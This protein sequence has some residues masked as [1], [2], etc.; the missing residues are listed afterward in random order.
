[1]NV[2]KIQYET[3]MNRQVP[4]HRRGRRGGWDTE[5]LVC[6]ADKSD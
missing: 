5:Y 6:K 4:L 1:M 2:V 3:A